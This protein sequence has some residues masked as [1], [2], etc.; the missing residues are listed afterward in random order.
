MYNSLDNLNGYPIN[1]S[2][3]SR[4]PSVRVQD[5]IDFK[6]MTTLH[7]MMNYTASYNKP[8]HPGDFG[9]FN[10]RTGKATGTLAD[11]LQRRSV[12]SANCFYMQ[13]YGTNKIEFT[14]TT[15]SDPLCVVVPKARRI[16][17]WS[18][19][20]WIFK[21]RTWIAMTVTQSLLFV[22]GHLYQ[23]A[24]QYIHQDLSRKYHLAFDTYAILVSQPISTE[25]S[26]RF[27]LLLA[28]PI[29]YNLIMTATLESN[30]VK[31][32]TAVTYFED[33][34]TL[35]ALSESNLILYTTFLSGSNHSSG[36]NRALYQKQ[37][38]PPD[39]TETELLR[40]LCEHRNFSTLERY[41]DMLYVYRGGIR[42][43]DGSKC[44]HTMKEFIATYHF[45]YIVYHGCP[46]LPKINS[47]ISQS[48]QAGLIEY[49]YSFFKKP[50]Q[51][52]R[53]CARSLTIEDVL[54]PLILLITGLT[55]S[56]LILFCE[57]YVNKYTNRK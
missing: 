18:K 24:S 36:I 1:L 26:R 50:S 20:L 8:S 16:P 35:Q 30:F 25:T 54:A 45:G 55:S 13:D 31:T 51:P 23:W 22:V 49:W 11:I 4:L 52:V 37:R 40:D 41:E 9:T 38:Q 47:Y 14:T 32:Y 7:R 3:F 57:I 46:Y 34:D 29:L 39:W 48:Q 15:Y 44:I 5:T 21:K 10:K 6:L 12:I 42:S 19:I 2:A 17:Q 28:S 43:P 33:I 56:T 27:S 53:A